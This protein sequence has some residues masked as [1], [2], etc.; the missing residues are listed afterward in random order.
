MFILDK[1]HVI[2]KS[3]LKDI[4]INDV[5]D[6]SLNQYLFEVEILPSST[7][8]SPN[9]Y[10][11][12]TNTMNDK[13][14]WIEAFKS[15]VRFGIGAKD[16]ENIKM[17]SSNQEKADD[18][19][20]K[21]TSMPISEASQALD[22]S[23]VD[24]ETKKRFQER[25]DIANN[26][27]KELRKKNI[28]DGSTIKQ[29]EDELKQAIY[30]I[31]Q[32]NFELSSAHEELLMADKI[33]EL[34]NETEARLEH[35]EIKL[36]DYNT[37][38]NGL[39]EILMEKS[40]MNIFLQYEVEGLK[41]E[42]SETNSKHLI[43][44]DNLE[45]ELK[46]L[47]LKINDANE[48]TSSVLT[49]LEIKNTEIENLGKLNENN[50]LTI[51]QLLEKIHDHEIH[52]K[53]AENKFKSDIESYKETIADKQFSI[54]KF[55]KLLE[56]SENQFS[57]VTA[58]NK[59]KANEIIELNMKINTLNV[60]IVNQK[61]A[62]DKEVE[63]L[64]EQLSIKTTEADILLADISKI[65][66]KVDSAQVILKPRTHSDPKAQSQKINKLLQ[67]IEDLTVNIFNAKNEN[68][69]IEEL[70]KNQISKT[71]ELEEDNN[72]L[73]EI[74]NNYSLIIKRS[75]DEVRK[76]LKSEEDLKQIVEK[77]NENI[78]ELESQILNL[79]E[80]ANHYVT[81]IDYFSNETKNLQNQILI[82]TKEHKAELHKLEISNN[83]SK[84]VLKNLEESHK[85]TINILTLKMEEYCKAISECNK[86]IMLLEAKLKSQ[87]NIIEGM[88]K[89]K[90]NL[91]SKQEEMLL[92]SNKIMCMKLSTEKE[93][94]D[95]KRKLEEVIAMSREEEKKSLDIKSQWHEA[96][97]QVEQL[98]EQV[99]YLTNENSVNLKCNQELSSKV[100]KMEETNG[101][102][103]ETLELKIIDLNQMLI[104]TQ[105]QAKS[106]EENFDEET[107]KVILLNNEKINALAK[108]KDLEKQI[109]QLK[110]Q[111]HSTTRNEKLLESNVLDLNARI[112]ILM[113]EQKNYEKR[114]NELQSN[115]LDVQEENKRVQNSIDFLKEENEQ[116][117][118]LE[119]EKESLKKC[120]ENNQIL[121]G[122]IENLK[123]I[124]Q[125]EQTEK[126]TMTEKNQEL[127]NRIR[128][129]LDAALLNY[130]SALEE[131][132][133]KQKSLNSQA[134]KL[135]EC[136]LENKALKLKLIDQENIF[137]IQ[138]GEINE[139][140]FRE[141]EYKSSV[142]SL[143]EII[144]TLTNRIQTS[145]SR[146]QEYK[147]LVFLKAK[148]IDKLNEEILVTDL[149]LASEVKLKGEEIEKLESQ[150][151][152]LNTA[153]EKLEIKN[154]TDSERM[155]QEV[156]TLMDK[157]DIKLN[158]SK[159][160]NEHL[161]EICKSE[162]LGE[163]N[164]LFL[165]NERLKAL[166]I[167]LLKKF[168]NSQL[169]INE[170][171]N[172]F[173]LIPPLKNSLLI[174]LGKIVDKNEAHL[175]KIIEKCFLSQKQFLIDVFSS[176]LRLKEEKLANDDKLTL[177]AD[178]KNNEILNK[179]KKMEVESVENE[180]LI[181]NGLE[182]LKNR[183]DLI[184]QQT[185]L[186]K[187]MAL[188]DLKTKIDEMASLNW[189]FERN[190]EVA[191]FKEKEMNDLE[192]QFMRLYEESQKTYKNLSEEL[193]QKKSRVEELMAENL[194]LR[195]SISISTR[196]LE[197]SCIE[198]LGQ[199]KRIN[200]LDKLNK[201]KN[202][203]ALRIFGPI[204]ADVNFGKE[205]NTKQLTSHLFSEHGNL[206]KELE[207]T[208][209]N[210]AASFTNGILITQKNEFQMNELLQKSNEIWESQ[211][212]EMNFQTKICEEMQYKRRNRPYYGNKLHYS[213]VSPVILVE[214]TKN[215]KNII[216][217]HKFKIEPIE[218]TEDGY[219]NNEILEP[220]FL[221]SKV[222]IGTLEN[223]KVNKTIKKRRPLIEP[224]LIMKDNEDIHSR[225]SILD[226]VDGIFTEQKHSILND[227]VETTNDFISNEQ[228]LSKIR[229]SSIIAS[230]A[231]TQGGANHLNEM[232]QF[233]EFMVLIEKDADQK[234]IF[235]ST[236]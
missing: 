111:L 9:R 172:L 206:Q 175:E 84:S 22:T 208:K 31:N 138:K 200:D 220:L 233:R 132:E 40:D 135:H 225:Y 203:T 223:N 15:V 224:V 78:V 3:P 99:S 93:L 100:K 59:E 143:N 14:D 157:Q 236:I 121:T 79:D 169:C 160:A 46:D 68:N 62:Y 146:A 21:G 32:K 36:K 6:K 139:Y 38:F 174:K 112:D 168:S 17:T 189:E 72:K 64:K 120:E 105:K 90:D 228:H 199:Q 27:I 137:R 231:L 133:L 180:K 213:N 11:I 57:I 29:K 167:S 210:D 177:L 128:R 127:I 73:T 161:L 130:Q 18:D 184:V 58:H 136:I 20:D 209:L 102:N 96:Q 23:Y 82:L 28:Q 51:S 10:I 19:E 141:T 110:N 97:Y 43:E 70:L 205:N 152:T 126:I 204:E 140:E 5:V 190:K 50:N 116:L 142:S 162:W 217:Q 226:P 178:E 88:Q 215:E 193:F 26:T 134:K 179:F 13:S 91:N 153:I 39:I 34:L 229:P 25:I 148:E 85:Q 214:K 176:V 197:L 41:K 198:I 124:L 44:K 98:K 154:K 194:A 47:T 48:K 69:E 123:L 74:I 109:S 2:E 212:K 156:L 56:A 87:T 149:R 4:R 118:I 94:E 103:I 196:K 218:I 37:A 235:F 182:S 211:R 150:I 75:E 77:L 192:T 86:E 222:T 52:E 170:I 163:K 115:L 159:A 76:S 166:L 71:K 61:C 232:T 7:F 145:N 202:E 16:I 54:E 125:I 122:D 173:G 164:L 114:I 106:L 60:D 171:A 66:E 234:N 24:L 201:A 49:E 165:N 113:L 65:E 185:M 55:E 63:N 191:K 230:H 95:I 227:T 83:E 35:S 104:S 158:E 81:E 53:Y 147:S 33:R 155:K 12:S 89:E 67:R 144:A 216:K 186:A 221:R 30:D 151:K 188:N 108:A 1:N 207:Q 101:F 107:R 187:D 92:E 42:I 181:L 117:R 119:N 45:N 129:D 195:E 8:D 183:Y 80:K 219:V 131:S